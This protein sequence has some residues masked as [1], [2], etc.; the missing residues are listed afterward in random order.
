MDDALAL[1]P[2]TAGAAGPQCKRMG[3]AATRQ[4]HMQ[5]AGD[6]HAGQRQQ[7]ALLC[8]ALHSYRRSQQIQLCKAGRLQVGCA[9]TTSRLGEC[10]SLQRLSVML[11]LVNRQH[12]AGF[13]CVSVTAQHLGLWV[14]AV[15]GQHVEAARCFAWIECFLCITAV[16][17][18]QTSC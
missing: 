2:S 3:R 6:V 17:V 15:V 9:G 7:S 16:A 18:H 10:R 14:P 4:V 5:R 1:L 13:W 8:A 12:P 11:Q